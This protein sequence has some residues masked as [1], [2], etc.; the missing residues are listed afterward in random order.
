M[1]KKVLSSF[2]WLAVFCM[3]IAILF[4][5]IPFDPSTKFVFWFLFVT[6]F[7]T[8]GSLRSP[9][10]A[11]L[12]IP[13]NGE[14]VMVSMAGKLYKGKQITVL[15]MAGGSYMVNVD[16][17]ASE[18]SEPTPTETPVKIKKR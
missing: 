7:F 13:L 6:A 11:P 1:F 3:L 2:L 16:P 15:R 8:L 17:D 14:K 4:R 18:E 9:K 12:M 5:I 10:N